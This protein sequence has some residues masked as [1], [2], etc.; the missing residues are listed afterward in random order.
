[1]SVHFFFLPKSLFH[2]MSRCSAKGCAPALHKTVFRSRCCSAIKECW[3]DKRKRLGSMFTSHC[4]R[5]QVSFPAA[6]ESQAWGRPLCGMGVSDH[7]RQ[8]YDT[9]G[10]KEGVLFCYKCNE[11]VTLTHTSFYTTGYK[12][13]GCFLL[14]LIHLRSL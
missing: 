8:S 7:V 14:P 5:V 3:L 10:W 1:M 11:D 13:C 12:F 4:R 9:T 2:C 6:V